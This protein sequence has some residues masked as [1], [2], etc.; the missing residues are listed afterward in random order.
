MEAH[1]IVSKSKFL[2]R[3]LRHN[4][5]LIGV[6]LDG[7]GWARVDE[8][9]ALINQRGMLF[10]LDMLKEVVEKN[11]KKRFSFNEDGTMIRA[12][13]GHSIPVELDLQPVPPP[14]FL[15]HGTTERAVE[16]IRVKGILRGRRNHVHL[17][18]DRE[19][20]EKVGK[21]H[22]RPTVIVIRAGEMHAAG[23]VF[24][25]SANGVWLTKYVPPEF[26]L[27]S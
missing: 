9:L 1:E 3:V 12:N 21:R 26:L 10:T 27:A 18:I 25:L 17:S 23:H 14:E 11:D 16:S 20:A 8:L 13:Q 6:T 7:R 4:P 5:G 24:Y 15:F 2:S 19:T 22:G